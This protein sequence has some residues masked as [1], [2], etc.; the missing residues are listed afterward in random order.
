MEKMGFEL[1][2]VKSF[3]ELCADS[4]FG[5]EDICQK[6]KRTTVLKIFTLY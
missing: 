4:P 3:S 5:V 2:E 1:I 6:M